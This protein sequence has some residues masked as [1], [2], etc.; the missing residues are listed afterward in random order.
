MADNKYIP[1]MRKKYDE[2]IVRVVVA[3]VVTVGGGVV[4]G[5]AVVFI[6]VYKYVFDF[7]FTLLLCDKFH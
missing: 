5:V 3:C 2:E 7:F 1:R 4:R 6:V